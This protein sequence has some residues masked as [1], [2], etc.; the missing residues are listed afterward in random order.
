MDTGN[1]RILEEV[2]GILTEMEFFLLKDMELVF[3]SAVAT[4][5]LPEGD[6]FA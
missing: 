3:G 5:D 6:T 4:L 2:D 1:P